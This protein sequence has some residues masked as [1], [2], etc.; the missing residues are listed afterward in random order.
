MKSNSEAGG[1]IPG[2]TVALGSLPPKQLQK[3]QAD[4]QREVEIISASLVQLSNAVQRLSASRDNAER[5]GKME[6]DTDI[7]VPITSS[8]YVP[9]KLEDTSKVLI[10]IGTGF[11]VEKSPEAA[12][13][14]FAKRASILK[15]E[16]DRTTQ[17][18]TQKRQQLEAVS[19]VLQR[20]TA[21]LSAAA[22]SS[23]K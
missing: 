17:L 10:D 6:K 8:I 16:Q 18:H 22:G 15:E 4:L 1:G 5:I 11:F 19:A 3:I 23:S 13:E 7:M 12:K 14:H 9:G 21:E 20:K 2:G